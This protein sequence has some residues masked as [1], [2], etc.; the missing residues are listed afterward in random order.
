MDTYFN[1]KKMV[2]V[3][4]SVVV[5]IIDAFVLVY[6][7]DTKDKQVNEDY[8]GDSYT[9]EAEL[10]IES[11]IEEEEVAA[12]TEYVAPEP[13][14]LFNMQEFLGE[15]DDILFYANGDVDNMGN[16]YPYMIYCSN[17]QQ[18]DGKEPE[19]VTYALNEKYS[20]LKFVL[21]LRAQENDETGQGWLEFYDAD[22][23]QKIFETTHFTAGVKPEEFSV[24]LTGIQTLKIVVGSDSEVYS[25]NGS[26]FLMTT[27]FMLYE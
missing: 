23:N 3:I 27:E 2:L 18:F 24:D 12:E 20:E 1:T 6:M 13:V 7:F 25:G 10:P 22:T 26:V 5:V 11:Q 4:L 16:S 19:S 15:L 9:A 8:G 17:Y 14:A 21:G